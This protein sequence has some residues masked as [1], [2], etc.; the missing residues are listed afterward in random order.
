MVQPQPAAL[1]GLSGKSGEGNGPRWTVYTSPATGRVLGIRGKQRDALQFLIDW[2]H[3]LLSGRLGRTIL[4][5][6]AVSTILLSLSGLWLWWPAGWAPSRFRPRAAARPLHYAVGFWAMWPL[7]T[8]A[9]TATYFVWREPIDRA[10]GV[11]TTK[12]VAA[13]VEGAQAADSARPKPHHDNPPPT[14]LMAAAQATEPSARFVQLRFPEG[15]SGTYTATFDTSREDYRDGP[16]SVTLRVV[17]GDISVVKVWFW[18]DGLRARRWLGWLPRIHQAEFG[19]EANP[20]ARALW[21]AT[22]LMPAVLFVSGLLMWRRRLAASAI[23]TK[24]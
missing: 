22:G 9:T 14:K 21:S 5:Y 23:K 12:A 18:R 1:L 20:I 3:N 17:N 13:V 19:G 24:V 2:H 8:I 11:P 4:G 10:F 7:L 15:L 16:N 6:L